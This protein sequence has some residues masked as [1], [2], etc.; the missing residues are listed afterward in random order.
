LAHRPRVDFTREELSAVLARY[1]VG[2]I[3][4]IEKLQKGSRRSPKAIITTDS[5]KY[6]L[7]RR[8]KGRDH[9][10][11]VAFAHGIQQYLSSKDFALAQLVLLKGGDDTMVIIGGLIYEMFEYVAGFPYDKSLEATFDGGKTLAEFHGLIKDYET[12]WEPSGRGYVDANGVRN[13]LNGVPASIGKHDSVFGKEADLLAT[14][15]GIYDSY[16]KACEQTLG[17]GYRDFPIQ[18]VHSDW[19]P[20]N[21]LFMNGEVEA[22]TDYDSLHL[23]AKETDIANG[24]LQFS[25]IGGPVDPTQWPAELDEDRFREFLLGYDEVGD[26]SP[27]QMQILPS[28]MIQ[29]LISEAVMP[30][31]ATGSFGHLEGFRFLQMICRKVRWLEQNGERLVTAMQ[32]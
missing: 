14:V 28:L 27:E 3:E 7:K 21:M 26:I 32:V 23:L 6:L 9:P 20:G 5:G 11:K 29:A 31:A 8:A 24:A 22:V 18:I 10:M 30:I 12:D 4:K 17:Y 15:S 25:I 13:C 2:A 16:E 19:H 1:D